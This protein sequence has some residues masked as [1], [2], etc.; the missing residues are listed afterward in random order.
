[1]KMQVYVF[2]IDVNALRSVPMRSVVLFGLS[3]V[4]IN[5]LIYNITL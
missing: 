2:G 5:A 1:L 4:C 3:D